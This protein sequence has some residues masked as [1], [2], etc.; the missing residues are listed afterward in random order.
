MPR[1]VC[2]ILG[3]EVMLAPADK[4]RDVVSYWRALFLIGVPC[5][6][7]ACLVSYWRAL[8]LIG[9]PCFLL[10]C[11]VSYWHAS[12]S[13]SKIEQDFG[14]NGSDLT[15]FNAPSVMVDFSALDAPVLRK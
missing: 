10:A 14:S 12:Q 11:L 13:G 6:L 5:F 1:L 3:R 15:A 7:L 4:P 9:V 2:G 8:F